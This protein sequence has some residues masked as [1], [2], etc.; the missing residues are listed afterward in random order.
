MKTMNREPW[1][2]QIDDFLDDDLDDVAKAAFQAHLNSCEDC[3]AVVEET[4][5]LTNLMQSAWN[6]IELGEPQITL[7][8]KRESKVAQESRKRSRIGLGV[9]AAVAATIL[10]AIGLSTYLP[11]DQPDIAELPSDVEQ[12]IE[13]IAEEM[14]STNTE[15][16]PTFR[17]S[18]ASIEFDEK[19]TGVKLETN[20][21]FTVYQ[22]APKVTFKQTN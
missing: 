1:C 18:F 5:Q 3:R 9:L 6:R 12:P 20:S 13:P 19:T 15:V 4:Q 7:A 2:Q 11:T 17:P 22:V 10:I 8:A 14:E 21:R 16:V